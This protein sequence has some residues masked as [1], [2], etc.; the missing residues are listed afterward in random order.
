MV[1][2]MSYVKT[3]GEIREI[4][5]T[6]REDV[7]QEGIDAVA[8]SYNMSYVDYCQYSIDELIEQFVAIEVEHMYK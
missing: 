2:I 3:V 1:N 7:K 4:R 5:E 6:L 8:A